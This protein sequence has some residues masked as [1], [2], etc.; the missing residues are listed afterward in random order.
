MYTNCVLVAFT[1]DKGRRAVKEHPDNLS[2]KVEVHKFRTCGSYTRQGPRRSKGQ[3]KGRRAVEEHPDNLS[4]KVEVHK[5]C[6]CGSYTRQ[7]PRRSKGRRAV[8]EHPDNLS[9]KVEEQIRTV[10]TQDRPA[11]GR[12]AP[13]QPV[14]QGRSTQ[15]RT[16]SPKNHT[17]TPNTPQPPKKQ[18]PTTTPTPKPPKKHKTSYTRQGPACVE[19]PDNLSA[20]VEEK[21]TR[22]G[23]R[24]VEAPP[25]T[26]PP[27]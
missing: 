13:R 3:H 19:H 25:T 11:C 18:T 16:G 20:K 6:T 14:R 26:C 17:N 21:P 23:R 2:A 22:Q 10:L 12:S 7:G 5:F 9:A 4:A 24:A 27:R 8:K 15:I 1:Q